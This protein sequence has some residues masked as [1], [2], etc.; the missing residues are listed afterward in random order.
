VSAVGGAPK[1]LTSGPAGQEAVFVVVRGMGSEP[2]YL[3]SRPGP[4][5]SLSDFPVLC[6]FP[7]L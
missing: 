3:G 1:K 6:R 4:S 2:E 5:V 7:Y